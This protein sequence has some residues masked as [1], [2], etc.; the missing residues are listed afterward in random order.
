MSRSLARELIPGL[1][2]RT[3]PACKR[4]MWSPYWD[5]RD[6]PPGLKATVDHIKPRWRGGTNAPRNLRVICADCNIRKGGSYEKPSPERP[7]TAGSIA[8]GFVRIRR[9]KG[10]LRDQWKGDQTDHG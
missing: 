4:R 7:P 6:G 9:R 8:G 5:Q 10:R 2:D 1:Q 3:C